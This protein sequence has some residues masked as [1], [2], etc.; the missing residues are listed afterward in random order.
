MGRIGIADILRKMR[1]IDILV[2]E[3]KQMPCA[4]PGPEGTKRD[5]GL[6]LEQMQESRWRQI[7]RRGAIG[8]GH[9]AAREIIKR[10]CGASDTAIDI[11]LRKTLT[12]R[13]LVELGGGK[14]AAASPQTQGF[15]SGANSPHNGRRVGAGSSGA[16][17]IHCRGID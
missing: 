5:A 7:D 6:L 12:E 9:L 4:L 2:D 16:Q 11:A 15:V 13:H 17:V 1:E 3:V 14:T 10:R 8:G